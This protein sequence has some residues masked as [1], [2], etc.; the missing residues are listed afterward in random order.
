MSLL[1]PQ[2]LTRGSILEFTKKTKE[3]KKLFTINK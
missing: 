1:S 2:P 3:K